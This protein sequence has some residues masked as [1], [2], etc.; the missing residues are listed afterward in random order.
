M[1]NLQIALACS[2]NPRTRPIIDGRIKPDGIDLHVTVV[3]PSEM[4]W[5][6]LHFEEFDVSEMSMSSLTMA[7][8]NGDKR[9][10]GIP[11]F[12]SRSF[13]HTGITVRADAG[14]EGPE[15]LKGKRVGVPEYQQTAA[16][17][18]RAALEHVYGIKAADMRWWMER[19]EE[20]SHGGATGFTPP[21]DIEF[22]YI[23]KESSMGAMM[24][25]GELDASL[26]YLAGGNLVD[27]STADLRR[28]S[29]F[30]PLFPDRQAEGINYYRQTGFY[31]INHGFVVKR[32]VYEKHPW[33]VLNIFN[34]FSRARDLWLNEVRDNISPYL[35]TGTLS[36]GEKSELPNLFPY[37]VRANNEILNAI[38]R[39]SHEQGLTPRVVALNEVFAPQTLDL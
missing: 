13:Y 34:A 37:G 11:I 9:W 33:V 23:P 16:L 12:T 1:P 30:K 35:A 39:F 5:R 26:L 18:A 27:R 2:S 36:L 6:Q 3:H 17:W 10:V 28:D 21:A 4:F 22:H 32:E 25:A 20:M 24:Q 15:D 14:I 29:R 31:P 8:A 7:V 19:N 38:P